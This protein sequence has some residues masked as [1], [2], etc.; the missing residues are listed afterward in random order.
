KEAGSIEQITIYPNP[1]TTAFTIETDVAIQNI[2]LFDITGRQIPIQINK[3]MGTYR[4]SF[5]SLP[6]GMYYLRSISD[7][8]KGIQA[9]TKVIFINK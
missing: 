1:A 7:T 8:N 9:C 6:D 3:D 2:E 5:S 4:V